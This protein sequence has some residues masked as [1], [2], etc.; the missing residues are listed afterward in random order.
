MEAVTSTRAEMC[1]GQASEGTRVV[2]GWNTVPREEAVQE[3]SLVALTRARARCV[4]APKGL[5]EGLKQ[6]DNTAKCSLEDHP[7]AG[8]ECQPR[9]G[10]LV[11]RPGR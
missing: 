4:R 1:E 5:P 2:W 10:S 11:R 7:S 3:R 9:S 6:G 8:L